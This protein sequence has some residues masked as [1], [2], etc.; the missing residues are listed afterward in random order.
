MSGRMMTIVPTR[1]RPENAKA[2][3]EQFLDVT[4]FSDLVFGVDDDDPALREYQ[5]IHLPDGVFMLVNPRMRQGGTLNLIAKDMA[6]KYDFLTSINDDHRPRTNRWD[7]F[8]MGEIELMGG[9]GFAYG[10]DLI[11]G[12]ALPTTV[13]VSS[14]IVRTLGYMAPP[15]L[16]HMFI[17]DFWRDLGKMINRLVYRQDIIMEHMHPIAHKAEWDD[18]YA[19]VNG[20]EQWAHDEAV[21]KAY[22]ESGELRRAAHLIMQ[23]W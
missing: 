8:L 1:G 13:T 16:Q 4:T 21:W 20:G 9:W 23:S 6:E 10:N 14:N 12:R 5:S 22:Q 15:N 7:E 2:L 19:E 17:D 3:I 11:H 18:R